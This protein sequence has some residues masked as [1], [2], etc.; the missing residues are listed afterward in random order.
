M[1]HVIVTE[2]LSLVQLSLHWYIAETV[3]NN[4][5]VWPNVADQENKDRVHYVKYLHYARYLNIET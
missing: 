5:S 3:I 1:P 4:I 2:G